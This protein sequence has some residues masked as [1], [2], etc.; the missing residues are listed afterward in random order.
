MVSILFKKNA[1]FAIFTPIDIQSSMSKRLIKINYYIIWAIFLFKEKTRK[2]GLKIPCLVVEEP[3]CPECRP[4]FCPWWSSPYEL[5]KTVH[6]APADPPKL[7]QAGWRPLFFLSRS[8]EICRF[9][10]GGSAQGELETNSEV[11]PAQE[12]EDNGGLHSL[13]YGWSPAD[14]GPAFRN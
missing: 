2:S 11:S 14:R 6:S 10:S 8:Q 12:P 1:H 4:C 5:R 7:M 9:G 3:A 13:A